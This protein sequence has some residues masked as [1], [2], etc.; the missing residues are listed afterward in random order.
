MLNDPLVGN[1]Q[2]P[3]VI[4]RAK[5]ERHKFG[6]FYYRFPHGESASDVV[7]I[8]LVGMTDMFA[9]IHTKSS[10]VFSDEY[11][12][13]TE[14]QRSWTLFG[15]ALS[16]D[17]HKTMLLSRTESQYVSFWLDTFGTP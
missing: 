5:S 15:G 14:Y 8:H 4:R 7:C 6:S 2:D 12:S 11:K 13:S 16:P 10:H 3:L 9:R 17:E 1:Y